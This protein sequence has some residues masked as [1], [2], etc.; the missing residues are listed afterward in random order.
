MVMVFVPRTGATRP[1][2]GGRRRRDPALAAAV[3]TTTSP[4]PVWQQGVS[5]QHAVI[6]PR[7]DRQGRAASA[8]FPARCRFS[9]AV[10]SR[11]V[12]LISN[13]RARWVP[14]EEHPVDIGESC[15]WVN[16]HFGV[17]RAA[18][19]GT[20]RGSHEHASDGKIGNSCFSFVGGTA[21][22]SISSRLIFAD[23]QREVAS[24]R[25]V[26]RCPRWWRRNEPLDGTA[27]TEGRRGELLCRADMAREADRL[28]TSGLSGSAVA[29]RLGI[30]VR[31]LTIAGEALSGVGCR[32]GRRPSTCGAGGAA[33]S[34]GAG[35]ADAVE[36]SA[37][38]GQ[39]RWAVGLGTR[40]DE[41]WPRRGI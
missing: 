12:A 21:E 33:G 20:H 5:F 23:D 22:W 41:C 30:P 35:R 8:R 17:D 6:T 16:Y 7:G 29:R 13:L 9:A 1:T 4:L 34:T 37:R 38:D 31:T 40:R 26:R 36:R 10:P 2:L 19:L 39:R 3:G 27:G 15:L 14:D 28:L 18:V 24:D 11:C 25:E 32:P